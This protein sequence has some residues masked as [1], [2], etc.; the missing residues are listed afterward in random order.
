MYKAPGP[1]GSHRDDGGSGLFG[2]EVSLTSLARTKRS[3]GLGFTWGTI[4]I[5]SGKPLL[6]LSTMSYIQRWL[7]GLAITGKK[8]KVLSR[9]APQKGIE[10]ELS[11]RRNTS[12]S[13]V[14]KEK[15]HSEGERRGKVISQNDKSYEVVGGGRK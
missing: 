5:A 4:I 2:H 7:K 11:T 14:T 13:V 6:A 1:A 8:T 15:S 9:I 12:T 3:L 10:L